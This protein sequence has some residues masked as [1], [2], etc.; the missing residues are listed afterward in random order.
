M[1]RAERGV[2]L[3]KRWRLR[4]GVT[5]DQ[6]RVLVVSAIVPHY[7]TLCD[8]VV[9]GLEAVGPREVLAIQRWPDRSTLETTMQGPRFDD[10]WQAY[11]PILA[12]WDAALEYVD[13]WE[14]EN[15]LDS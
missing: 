13:E 1:A 15:L 14:G 2:T 6:V 7:R 5:I 11:Q 4:D 10:W 8:D 12:V 9:L 3:Y